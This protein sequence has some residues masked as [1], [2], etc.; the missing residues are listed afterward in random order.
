MKINVNDWIELS[1]ANSGSINANGYKKSLSEL[2]NSVL[3]TLNKSDPD[4]FV[5]NVVQRK[6]TTE[7]H[8]KYFSE[9]TL[10]TPQFPISHKITVILIP[11]NTDTTNLFLGANVGLNDSSSLIQVYVNNKNTIEDI[12]NKKSLLETIT[13]HELVHIFKHL[14]GEYQKKG[15]DFVRIT[16]DGYEI[17]GKKYTSSGSEIDAF[18]TQINVE[19]K[20]IYQKNK[21]LEF[22]DALKINETFIKY[23]EMLNKSFNIGNANIFRISETDPTKK[24]KKYIL[25]KIY[26][27]WKEELK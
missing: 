5:V 2:F 10:I 9:P 15:N 19:L 25:K 27:Y 18:I 12:I 1:E 11:K 14:R 23:F 16:K 22:S 6:R 26:H 3:S 17:N 13:S 21:N 24:I 4:D 20:N 8:M 7:Y